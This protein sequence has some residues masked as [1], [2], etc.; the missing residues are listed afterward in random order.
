VAGE[1]RTANS[2]QR[3]PAEAVASGQWSVAGK[4]G[5]VQ[6]LLPMWRSRIPAKKLLFSAI[7]R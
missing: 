2:E 6:P 7:N 5:L 3:A 1:Q 4:P